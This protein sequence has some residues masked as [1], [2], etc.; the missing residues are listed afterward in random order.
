MRRCKLTYWTGNNGDEGEFAVVEVLLNEADIKSLMGV[1]PPKFIEMII[2]DGEWML[3]P[4]ENIN[5]LMQV[6]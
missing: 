6:Y 1:K 2:G 4:T 3:I 5:K